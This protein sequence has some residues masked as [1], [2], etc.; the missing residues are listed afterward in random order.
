MLSTFFI[1]DMLKE[2]IGWRLKRHAEKEFFKWMATWAMTIDNPSNIGFDGSAFILPELKIQTHIL[3]SEPDEN[4]LFAAFAETLTERRQARKKSL[5]DR[6]KLTSEIVKDTEQCLV[7]CD[8]NYESE[9]LKNTI[10]NSVEVKGSDTSQ[11]KENA[12]IGFSNGTVKTLIS[13][14]SICGFGMNW[15]NCHD[16]V[17]CGLS[18]SFEQFY[19]AVRRCYRFG[20][21]K[22]VNVHV[23]ISEAETNVLTNIQR[24]QAEH[25]RMKE[26]MIAIMSDISKAEIYNHPFSNATYKPQQQM[27]L[28]NF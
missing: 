16:M 8:F 15:Q 24:K 11:H 7:W 2:H 12:M 22:Q 28:P 17:F 1:N 4:R 13:K 23:I 10:P 26:E 9:E 20:Q 3:D 14:P 18:D 25:N 6:V 19:Q 5:A 21:T 27:M